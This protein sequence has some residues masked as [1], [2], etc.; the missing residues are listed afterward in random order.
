LPAA[1]AAAAAAAAVTKQ[2]GAQPQ[3]AAGSTIWKKP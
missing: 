2:L 1:A 3:L